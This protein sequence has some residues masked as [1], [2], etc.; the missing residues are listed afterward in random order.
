[1]PFTF[2][3]MGGWLGLNLARLPVVN[4]HPFD[5]L[6][7]A[8]QVALVNGIIGSVLGAL[9]A[10]PAT[11]RELVGAAAG[12]VLLL[13][14]LVTV[15]LASSTPSASPPVLLVLR[16][17]ALLLLVLLSPLLRT[18][19]RVTAWQFHSNPPQGLKIVAGEVGVLV[20]VGLAVTIWA[21]QPTDPGGYD[22]TCLQSVWAVHRYAQ[23]QEWPE[24]RLHML[25]C[26]GANLDLDG[27]STIRVAFPD[28]SQQSQVCTTHNRALDI[29][30]RI[31]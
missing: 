2:G 15:A 28:T 29:S 30:C 23:V 21:G 8:L 1:M 12:I 5:Y 31:E 26:E 11:R 7:P 18:V 17:A 4:P 3:I 19:V 14:G 6:G 9:I 27:Q 22:A 25:S 16:S 20:V 10:W 24:Y 13:S